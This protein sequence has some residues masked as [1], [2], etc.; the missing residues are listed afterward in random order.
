METT[1]KPAVKIYLQ[2]YMH[3]ASG[4]Q[5]HSSESSVKS[6]DSELSRKHLLQYTVASTRGCIRG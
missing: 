2:K 3:A 5:T 1:Q 4:I 6:L